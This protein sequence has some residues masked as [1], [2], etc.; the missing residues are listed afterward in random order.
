MIDRNFFPEQRDFGNLTASDLDGTWL[1]RFLCLLSMCLINEVLLF[2]EYFQQR[3][4]LVVGENYAPRD[5]EWS[6]TVIIAI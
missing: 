6:I 1:L 2:L 3:H 4:R 5:C